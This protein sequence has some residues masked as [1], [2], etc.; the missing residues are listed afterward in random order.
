MNAEEAAQ[1]ITT[2]AESLDRDPAQFNFQIIVTGQSSV[3]HGGVGSISTATGGAPGSTAIGSVGSAS[4]GDIQIQRAEAGAQEGI[5]EVVAL[6]RELADAVR[7]S[8][9]EKSFTLL[10]KLRSASVVPAMLL[11][12]ITAV[13]TLANIPTAN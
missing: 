6:L 11:D 10:E 2:I 8:Q 9:E 12:T 4:V 13:L 7:G 3:S 1:L 5:A